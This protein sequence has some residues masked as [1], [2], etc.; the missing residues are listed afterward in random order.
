V[1]PDRLGGIGADPHRLDD[2]PPA[3]TRQAVGFPPCQLLAQP[4][5]VRVYVSAAAIDLTL[6]LP[7][8]PSLVGIQLV[9][10]VVAIETDATGVVLDATS[11][12]ALQATIGAF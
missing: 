7:S 6:A 8:T 10:Q 5:V 12:N 1:D 11:S 3:P 2:P 9:Q 4:F